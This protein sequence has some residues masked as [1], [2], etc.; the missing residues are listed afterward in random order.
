MRTRFHFY[1]LILFA[2]VLAACGGGEPEATATPTASRTAAPSATETREPTET[3]TPSITPT[4]TISETPTITATP[5]PDYVWGH[6][7]VAQA[8]CRFGPGG[9]YL[10]ATTLFEGD[11]VD[12]RGYM[13]LNENWW[14][15]EPV[16]G[17]GERARGCWVSQELVTVGGNRDRIFPIEDPHLVLPYTTQPYD[18]LTGVRASRNGTIVT[19][20]WD[21][22]DW[23][24]GDESFQN[25][26]LVEAWVCQNGEYM[27]RAYGTN[28]LSIQIQD[29]QTCSEA[30][31]GR[32][33]G[34]DKHGYTGWVSIPWP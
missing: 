8:S 30:S 1:A 4:P 13:E 20:S 22:F 7:N 15:V 28:D 6:I 17:E 23:L 3:A 24:P 29:E 26:Y 5:T 16:I 11:L 19:V 18:P 14:F 10:L 32:A 34:S 25:K 2:L 9:A 31:R 33:F 21:H 27:F 12:V